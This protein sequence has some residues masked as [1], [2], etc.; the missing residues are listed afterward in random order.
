[1]IIGFAERPNLLAKLIADII[2]KPS[3]MSERKAKYIVHGKP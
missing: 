2:K 1:M 3:I